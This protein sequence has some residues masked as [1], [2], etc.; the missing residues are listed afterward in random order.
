MYVD[1]LKISHMQ[2]TFVDDFL[3]RLEEQY[4]DFAL[5]MTIRVRLHNYIGMVLEFITKGK[6]RETMTKHTQ[7]IIY[8]AP[9]IWMSS[10]RPQLPST[11]FRF[12]SMEGTYQSNTRTSIGG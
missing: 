11:D 12:E 5:L 1:D 3:Q 9:R 7:I 2:S 6:V 10:R 4:G 8:T